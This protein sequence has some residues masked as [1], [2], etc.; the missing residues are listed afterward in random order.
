MRAVV[1]VLDSLGI[2]ATPDADKF[3]DSGPNTLGHIAEQD[4]RG[5]C[6]LEAVRCGYR[7]SC[8]KSSRWRSAR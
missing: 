6:D 2:G 3:G 1:P 8:W 7:I 5:W 4:V